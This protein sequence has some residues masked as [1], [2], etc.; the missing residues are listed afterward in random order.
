M[1]VL[2]AHRLDDHMMLSSTLG[3][4]SQVGCSLA[5]ISFFPGLRDARRYVVNGQCSRD[6]FAVGLQ[7]AGCPHGWPQAEMQDLPFAAGRACNIRRNSCGSM[8]T[9][10]GMGYKL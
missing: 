5:C 3:L 6:P 7:D 8:Q 2:L 1:M 10:N 9:T 4:I